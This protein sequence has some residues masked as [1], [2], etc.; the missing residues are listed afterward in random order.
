MSLIFTKKLGLRVWKMEVA[1]EK[2]DG[3][4][5]KTFEIV[6]AFFVINNKAKKSQFFEE[7]FFLADI[8]IDII[9]EMFFLT[10]SN[11]EINF[12]K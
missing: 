11:V 5:I 7:T 2:I 3:S 9:L 6:I 8:S 12:L 4:I 1:D 10:L